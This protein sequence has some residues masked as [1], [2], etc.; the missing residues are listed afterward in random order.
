MDDREHIEQERR[1]RFAFLK[2]L[3]DENRKLPSGLVQSLSAQAVGQGIG[4]SPDEGVKI[5]GFLKDKGLVRFMSMGPNVGITHYGIEEIEAALATPERPT[6]YFPSIQFMT[7][8]GGVHNSQVQQGTVGSSQ[9][10]TIAPEERLTLTAAIA[11]LRPQLVQISDP[12][13]R[14]EMVATVDTIDAQLKRRSPS[15]AILKE[16]LNSLRSM[17]EQVSAGLIVAK[18]L[19]LAQRSGLL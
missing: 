14:K 7:I 19:E 8:H 12:D 9:S 17:T 15:V 18:L 6:T 5:S 10:Q 2:Y 16:S 4:V 11:E 3:Y 13:T 1:N